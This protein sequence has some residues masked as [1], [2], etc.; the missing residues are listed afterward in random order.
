MGFRV[1]GLGCRVRGIGLRASGLERLE[2]LAYC[3]G[4][5]YS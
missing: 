3:F 2:S 5:S 4:G 1:S